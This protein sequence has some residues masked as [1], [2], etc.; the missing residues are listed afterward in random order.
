MCVVVAVFAIKVLCY[1]SSNGDRLVRVHA[2]RVKVPLVQTHSPI[3][4]T[5]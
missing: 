4:L 5:C 1:W 2:L 3:V